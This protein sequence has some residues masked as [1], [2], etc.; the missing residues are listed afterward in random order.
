MWSFTIEMIYF[1]DQININEPMGITI[2]PLKCKYEQQSIDICDVF[3][4]CPQ[5][6]TQSF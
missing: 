4:L 5:F 2:K 3:G 6:L 1:A